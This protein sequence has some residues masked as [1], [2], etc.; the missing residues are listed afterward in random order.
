MRIGPPSVLQLDEYPVNIPCRIAKTLALRAKLTISD[1]TGDMM[2]L[3]RTLL[4]A[5]MG[6]APLAALA[7]GT[8]DVAAEVAVD[9]LAPRSAEGLTLEEFRWIARPIIIFADTP[10]DPRVAEQLSLLAERPAALLERDVVIIVDTD[11]AARSDIRMALRP[12]GFNIVVVTKDG[13][14][15]LRRPAMRDVRELIRA[16][17]NFALRQEELSESR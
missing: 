16:I 17:D 6:L 8:T 9:P 11:P 14:V 2:T 4:I 13:A 15:G 5:L 10:A 1:E 7:Q 3:H 12:R